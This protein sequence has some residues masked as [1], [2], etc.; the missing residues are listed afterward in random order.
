MNVVSP[1]L[2]YSSSGP[3]VQLLGLAKSF[4]CSDQLPFPSDDSGNTP[5]CPLIR[6]FG[7][8]FHA[9]RTQDDD[10][11]QLLRDQVAAAEKQAEIRALQE[12]LA[13][14]EGGRGGSLRRKDEPN[15]HA[16]TGQPAAQEGHAESGEK[17]R[18]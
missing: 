17:L 6:L 8:W 18:I 1:T 16:S 15:H 10:A 3:C 5:R 14:L 13:E 4:M 7:K 11:L 2:L 9:A 12:R